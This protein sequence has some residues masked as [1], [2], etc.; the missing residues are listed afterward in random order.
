M[1]ERGPIGDPHG[2]RAQDRHK[3]MRLM[4]PP[5]LQPQRK[6]KR[7]QCPKELAGL[8]RKRFRHLVKC[9]EENNSLEYSDQGTIV[10]A[11]IAYA[12]VHALKAEADALRQE[13]QKNPNDQPLLKS[14]MGVVKTQIAAMRSQVEFEA[15]LILNP[16]ARARKP[17]PKQQPAP[18]TKRERLLS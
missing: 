1:G 11:A 15:K 3:N 2:R 18:Q 8:A 10:A 4:P 14:L 17:G 16:N 12:E 6:K 5:Q 9:L 7:P 13:R